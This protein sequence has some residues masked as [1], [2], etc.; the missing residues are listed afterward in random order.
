[1]A[2]LS[3]YLPTQLCVHTLPVHSLRMTRVT[4]LCRLIAKA[5]EIVT[6]FGGVALEGGLK[7]RL[8]VFQLD[9]FSKLPTLTLT[10]S[11]DND[12]QL[13]DKVRWI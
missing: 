1:M 7:G 10:K 9:A 6:C 4:R 2:Y 11:Q 8:G 13:N 3:V 12:K 5:G